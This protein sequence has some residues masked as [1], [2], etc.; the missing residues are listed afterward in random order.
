MKLISNPDP[1]ISRGALRKAFAWGKESPLLLE[2]DAILAVGAGRTKTKEM[3]PDADTKWWPDGLL[4]ESVLYAGL[5]A[6]LGQVR[7]V[8]P[9]TRA[10]E[11]C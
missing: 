9:P 1:F 7:F 6:R 3:D 2:T 5:L 4:L 10:G 11:R 8:F